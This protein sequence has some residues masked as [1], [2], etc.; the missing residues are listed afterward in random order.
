M[1]NQPIIAV[2]HLGCE[3]NRIDTEH[4]LGL[5]VQAGYQVDANEDLADY[6]IVNT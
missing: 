2:S 3:K 4:M 1:G 6:V 5:L